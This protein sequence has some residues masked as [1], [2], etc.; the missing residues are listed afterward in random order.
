[1]ILWN[2][3]VVE[4]RDDKTLKEAVIKRVDSDE[5]EK[6]SIDGIFIEISAETPVVFSDASA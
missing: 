1:M 5:L 3:V 2:R 6:L 4:L